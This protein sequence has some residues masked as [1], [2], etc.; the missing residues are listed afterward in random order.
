VAV[1]ESA[2]AAVLY[3]FSRLIGRMH[4]PQFRPTHKLSD[5]PHCVVELNCLWRLG[6]LPGGP[7]ATGSCSRSVLAFEW[8][9]APA[10]VPPDSQALRLA[11]VRGRTAMLRRFGGLPCAPADTAQ[12]D[13]TFQDLLKR[14]RCKRCGNSRPAP[15]YLVAGHH[16]VARFGPTPDWAVQ[17]VPS[18]ENERRQ[19]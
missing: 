6:R 3:L 5:W 17:L 9:D 1:D 19:P 4:P 10:D 16:R 7:H 11:G 14:L 18:L 15:V 2:A 12:G 8:A 13:M